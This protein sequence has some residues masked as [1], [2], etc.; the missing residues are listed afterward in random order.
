MS[1]IIKLSDRSHVL[2]RP[3]RY[4]GS[5][6]PVEQKR[7]YLKDGKIVFGNITYVPA[8]IKITREII[9]NSVDAI[10]KTK[11]GKTVKINI[12]EDK[13]IIED[14][15]TGIP[16]TKIHD[17]HGQEI[18]KL[19]PEA[20]WTELKTGSN[21]DDHSDATQAGQNGEG[22]T[23][24]NI[25]S[26]KFIGE[27]DDGKHY[28]KL[29]CKNNMSEI[30]TQVSKSK[31]KTG[32]KV[33]FYPDFEKLHMLKIDQFYSDL[34]YFELIY[35]A[36]TFP[37]IDFKFNNR[38]IKTKNF[39]LLY[40]E[41]FDDDIEFT[42]TDDVFIGISSSEDGY[43]FIHFINGLNVFNGGKVLDFIDAKVIGSL[44]EKFQ[45]RY[46]NIKRI[47]VKNKITLH[48]VI[49][50]LPLP[51]FADQIKSES[52]NLPSQFPE[53][54]KQINEIASSKFID[55][56]YKNKSIA[57]PIVD[58]FKAKEMIKDK[59]EIEKKVKKIKTPVKY[60]AA[61]KQK[62]YFIIS[63]GDS[64]IG[65]IINGVGRQFYGF[66]PIKGKTSNVLKDA[67]K[68]KSD[69]ELLE[70]SKILGID[71]SNNQDVL[72][73][74][75]IV[76]AADSDLDG[77][78]IVSLLLSYFYLTA[79][80]Y[81][82]AGKIFR[83]LTPI[84]ITYKRDKIDEMIFT[85]D[86]LSEYQK[87]NEGKSGIIYDYKKGLGTLYEEEWDELFRRYSFE[88]LLLE[89]K[90]DNE[91]DIKNLLAWMQEDREFR[92]Q[93]ISSN[94]DNFIIDAV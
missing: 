88:D 33:T 41:Y 53:Q 75:N 43:Q 3:A 70:I 15:S 46:P 7:P 57:S 58:L 32:T 49:K 52:V 34:I 72:S 79:E 45:K 22:S 84:V 9:D 44:T 36:A 42:E 81:L 66:Y 20:V 86:Q 54:A 25:F 76:I 2:K 13:I 85:F 28:F 69:N 60:W 5:I 71:F 17:E 90:L 27:T 21:F 78:H 65:S 4:I 39:R 14:D 94:I 87:K 55:K 31:G 62:K 89:I 61:S 68:I 29:T 10:I 35:L 83:F 64:A 51:R 93:I 77:N 73:Y 82:K 50:N 38:L 63:E 48:A 12:S 11:V 40:K 37:E 19:A 59:K 6:V 91:E 80:N 74:E 1:K 56:V 16:V 92:K 23:L 30:D 24:T 8:F 18:N 47:D 26:T 67:R